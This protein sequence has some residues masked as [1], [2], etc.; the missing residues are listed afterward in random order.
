MRPWQ[1]FALFGGWQTSLI[2]VA[3]VV[4]MIARDAAEVRGQKQA[5]ALHLRRDG[6]EYTQENRPGLL[7]DIA[8]MQEELARLRSERDRLSGDLARAT[9]RN[10]LDTAVSAVEGRASKFGP[11]RI[12]PVLQEDRAVGAFMTS[13][14][15][16]AIDRVSRLLR[17][18][19]ETSGNGR[20]FPDTAQ[21]LP[22]LN[23]L[24]DL[25]DRVDA[26]QGTGGVGRTAFGAGAMENVEALLELTRLEPL[27]NTLLEL[28]Q[29]GGEAALGDV[30]ERLEGFRAALAA[31]DRSWEGRPVTGLL[32]LAL[33][34]RAE[35][36]TM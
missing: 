27:L 35:D 11:D 26:L 33:L 25:L 32:L 34:R 16:Q 7:G 31:R 9:W 12:V 1:W 4:W 20:I 3:G 28:R 17:E 15:N 24:S 21:L 30:L 14:A 36:G 8:R 5:N 23:E 13:Q 19:S 10:V 2:L 18:V 22:Q 29:Q 6:F